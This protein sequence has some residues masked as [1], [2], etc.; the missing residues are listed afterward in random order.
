LDLAEAS[1]TYVVC[2]PVLNRERPPP[3]GPVYID[4]IIF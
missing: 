2:A 3:T 4:H 1:D